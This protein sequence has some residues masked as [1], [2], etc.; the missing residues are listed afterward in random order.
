MAIVWNHAFMYV[1]VY[2]GMSDYVSVYVSVC[3]TLISSVY[4]FELWSNI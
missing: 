3:F 4:L 1:R 2:V